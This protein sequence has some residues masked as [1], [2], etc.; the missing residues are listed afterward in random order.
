MQKKNRYDPYLILF[1][2][3]R[4][5]TKTKARANLCCFDADVTYQ[6]DKI[7][8]TSIIKIQVWDKDSARLG[9]SDDLIFETG[10]LVLKR[11]ILNC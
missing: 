5:V 7:R 11:V 8:N 4:N 1:I 9:N 3:G 10:S 2:D 6:S